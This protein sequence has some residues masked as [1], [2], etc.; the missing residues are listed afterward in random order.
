MNIDL[1]QTAPRVRNLEEAQALID[2]LWALSQTQARRIEEQ[3]R[4]I[5]ALTQRVQ[6]LEEQLGANSRN[7]SR[8]PSTD[9]NRYPHTKKSPGGRKPGG[10]LG[11][12]GKAR[13]L[14]AAD[15]VTQAHD[16]HPDPCPACGGAVRIAGLCARHQVVDLPP[17]QPIV[18]EYRLY[19]GVCRCVPVCAGAAAGIAKR[20]CREAWRLA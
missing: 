9:Q 14:L 16:C 5:E 15:Q 17:I 3:A 18:T 8:P 4:Q 20:A 19:A 11:H 7:S 2:V 12:P 10:Q 1:S 6:M 13:A